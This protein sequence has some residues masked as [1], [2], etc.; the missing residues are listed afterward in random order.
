M[1]LV[2]KQVTHKVFGKGSV[3]KHNDSYIIIS[4]P[5]GNKRFVFPDACGTHLTLIDQRAA[6]LVGKMVQKARQERKE[7]ELK[8][9]KLEALQN[10]KR[11]HC[12]KQERL[13]K[14]LK[15]QKTRK[16]HPCLHSVFWCKAQEQDDVFTRWSIF[17]GVIKSGKRKGQPRRL[18][19]INQNSACLLTARE[20]DV[21]E[22]DRRILGV[23]MVNET[24][25][26]KLCVD[27]Y[28]PAHS[29]YRIRL[30]EQESEKM[31]FWNYYVD[32]K[33]PR[34][35]VWNTGR[36]RYFENIWIAQILRDIITIKKNSPERVNVERFF[37]Y[38]CQM[39]QIGD[40][41]LPKP[42]GAL[43]RI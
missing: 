43:M 25:S 5:S 32:E 27:G 8:R 29:E 6:K 1:D 34:K 20:S 11:Q 31:L 38:F 22:K 28:I 19:R 13:A 35:M 2:N 36:H 23:F 26:G 9:K 17:T 40:G 14:E 21:P 16:A 4:F 15:A 10:E 30:S 41:E 7:E 39:N 18:A 12:L 24:F 33:Y 42:N 37:D 3:I